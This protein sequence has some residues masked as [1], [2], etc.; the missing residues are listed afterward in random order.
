MCSG[1]QPPQGAVLIYPVE[2]LVEMNGEAARQVKILRQLLD[3]K[4]ETVDGKLPALPL[5]NAAQMVSAQMDCADFMAG[6][7]V[8]YVTQ[9]AQAAI[10]IKN[11][12][13]IYSFQGLTDDGRFYVAAVLPIVFSR[14]PESGSQMFEGYDA[15]FQVYLDEVASELDAA[16]AS[17]FSS[18]L[19]SLDAMM[20]S[21][22]LGRD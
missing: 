18:G 10:P 5:F 19:S 3:E 6:S 17:H 15:A 9:Y 21:L 4:P 12:E 1:E 14:P 22:D 2:Q 16:D 8:R 11:S 13:L 20:K 7:G